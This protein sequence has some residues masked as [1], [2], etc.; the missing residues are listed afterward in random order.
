MLTRSFF[1][2]AC[3]DDTQSPI[4]QQIA[5]FEYMPQWIIVFNAVLSLI[6]NDFFF[7]VASN[8]ILTLLFYYL[9]LISHAL[10][11]TRPP[12][13]DSEL[14]QVDEFAFPDARYVATLT[15]AVVIGAGLLLDR[16]TKNSFG[17]LTRTLFF[18]SFV[19]YA[20]ALLINGYF[21][22]WQLLANTGLG[23]LIG[24]LFIF[25]YWKLV[26]QYD[27]AHDIRYWLSERLGYT[28]QL[29]TREAEAQRIIGEPKIRRQSHAAKGAQK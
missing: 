21:F 12:E 5:I 17:F 1:G 11:V 22:A 19:I 4:L 25:V 3:Y 6:D 15:Y 14:C 29:F 8:V 7:F 20:L 23:L 9:L 26:Y 28:Q 18:F 2:V 24:F 10:K 16:R 27:V 13:F